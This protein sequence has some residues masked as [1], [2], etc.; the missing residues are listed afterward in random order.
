MQGFLRFADDKH[1]GA[2]GADVCS[3]TYID[4]LHK[5]KKIVFDN[6]I[7]FGKKMLC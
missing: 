4:L 7:R 3:Q 1:A 5:N 2:Q 6:I